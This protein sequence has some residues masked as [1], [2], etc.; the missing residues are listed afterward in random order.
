MYKMVIADDEQIIRKGLLSIKWNEYDIEV[1][2]VAKNG[3]ELQEL[4][5]GNEFHVLLTDI[6]MP[7]A[8]GLE[9][10]QYLCQINPMSKTILLT[11]YDDFNYAKQAIHAGVF[12]YI[13]K[14]SSPEE[15]IECVK[16]ACVTIEK[17]K[18]A[19]DTM[20]KMEE[21]IKDYEQIVGICELTKEE[22]AN[23]DIRDIV[24]YIYQNYAEE[25]TLASLAEQFHFSTVYISSY[26]KKNTGHTF[27][28]I[29]TSIR[30]YYAAIY[31]KET[32]MKNSEIGQRIGI[33][34]E[35]Y[36]GQV[37]KKSYGITPYEFRK[38]KDDVGNNLKF[39]GQEIIE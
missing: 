7:G 18:N 8:S 34:D 36:F 10:A 3:I 9:M 13:L 25:L 27:L 1:I 24:T 31:L 38:R 2:G 12:D 11:G 15:I 32:K 30:M 28:E 4:I 22:P 39:L 14:P 17:E 20:R 21:Q 23:T 5:D 19:E 37:F 6:R 29:L 26:I 33:Q 16:R 35:R